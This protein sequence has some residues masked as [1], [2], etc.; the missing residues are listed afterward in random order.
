MKKYLVVTGNE[1]GLELDDTVDFKE[2]DEAEKMFSEYLDEYGCAAIYEVLPDKIVLF[3]K[4]H[5]F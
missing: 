3:K 5:N 4:K 1:Q 2:L